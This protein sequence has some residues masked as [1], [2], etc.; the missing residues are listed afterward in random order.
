MCACIRLLLGAEKSFVYLVTSLEQMK[1]EEG[2]TKMKG[3][4]LEVSVRREIQVSHLTPV[5][6]P[7]SK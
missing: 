6:P 2:Q 1:E 5:G 3:R 4:D 7:Y